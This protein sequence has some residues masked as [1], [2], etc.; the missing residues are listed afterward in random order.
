[1]LDLNRLR[2]LREVG[3]QGSFSGAAAAMAYTQPAISR[4]I[5]TLEREVGA[6]LVDRNPRGVRLTDAGA[7][8]VGHTEAVLARLCDAEDEVR[9]I[10]E[11]RGGRLRMAAFP[12]AAATLA[13]LA[14]A[15]FRRTHPDVKLT[16]TMAEPADALPG[17]L[18]GELD[19]AL[20]LDGMDD[21]LTTGIDRLWLFDDPMYIALPADHPLAARPHIRLE[22]FSEEEWMLGTTD[23]CPDARL[24]SRACREAGFEPRLTFQNDDYAAIAG[25]VAAGVGI[26]MIPD[27]ATTSIRGDIVLR[28]LGPS[29]PVRQ[30]VAATKTGGYRSPAAQAMLETL[31]QASATW[32]AARRGAAAA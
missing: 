3:R 25:F 32:V 22:D 23:R 13:P 16:L 27:L 2:V 15:A 28:R 21:A 19:V 18:C 5:A 26:A 7:A 9:A 10:S 31:I 1:M 6:T 4:Q 12:T 11:L 14:I 20:S 17:L 8:L 30:V 29:G 24:F